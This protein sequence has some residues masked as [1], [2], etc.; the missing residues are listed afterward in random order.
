MTDDLTVL[1]G[2]DVT[3]EQMRDACI[4]LLGQAIGIVGADVEALRELTRPVFTAIGALPYEPWPRTLWGGPLKEG[5][6]Q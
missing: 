5:R 6:P 4:V 2:T 1:D 3:D